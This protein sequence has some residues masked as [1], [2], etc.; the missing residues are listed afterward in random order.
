MSADF[1]VSK[2]KGTTD[3]FAKILFTGIIIRDYDDYDEINKNY[4]EK[5]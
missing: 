1:D 3:N 5:C 2:F 4:N